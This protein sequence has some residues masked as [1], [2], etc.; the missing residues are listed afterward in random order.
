VEAR[1][2]SS[3]YV[4]TVF[5]DSSESNLYVYTSTDATNWSL[6]A[7]PTY[8][9][10]SGLV[11]DP[12]IMLHTDGYYY[13]AY[14]NNW[15][16]SSF[17]IARSQN[18]INWSF[19]ATIPTASSSFTPVNT[20]APEFFHDP[21][22]GRVNIIVSLS[23]AS[24][25]PFKPY[26]L[27]ATDSTLK[28]WS[29]PTALSG[30]PNPTSGQLGFIDSFPVYLNNQYHLFLKN[31]TNGSKYVEHAVSS[32]LAGPYSFVQTGN[33]ASWG[34]AEGPCVSKLP[35]GKFRLWMDGF[36]SGKYI[37][38]DSSDLYSWSAYTTVSGGLSGFVRHGTVLKQ[39]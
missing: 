5:T 27:S 37:Y 24:Y 35:N 13:I 7:G 30:I 9:P 25:G 17:G 16:G 32:S 23:T 12:S 15:D 26:L 19:V 31:E 33:F 34:H 3:P 11:R 10:P 18:L 21:V 20:W 39:S 14:T 28:S 6:L 36:D 2:V 38:S 8:T 29:A 4:W 22:S 1:A